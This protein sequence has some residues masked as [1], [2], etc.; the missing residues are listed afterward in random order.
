MLSIGRLAEFSLSPPF[1]LVS[2]IKQLLIY[3]TYV[4]ISI[5]PFQIVEKVEIF[6]KLN[7]CKLI[8]WNAV[9]D[10]SNDLTAKI[11]SPHAAPGEVEQNRG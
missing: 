5:G 4:I 8:D 9:S 2:S 10:V 11:A 6:E 3:K 1:C 7:I